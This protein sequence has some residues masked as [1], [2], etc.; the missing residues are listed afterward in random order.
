MGYGTGSF[1]PG[2]CSNRT[3]CTLGN[4]ATEPYIAG[5]NVLLAHGSAVQLYRNKYQLDQEGIIGITLNLDWAEPL[6]NTPADIS[7][8][9]RRNEFGLAWFGDPIFFGE[10]PQS[11]IDFVGSRLQQFTVDEKQLIQGS[12]DFLGLNHY[13]TKYVSSCVDKSTAQGW[14]YDQCTAESKYDMN[15]TLIG[16][17][18]GSSWLNIVPWG[19]YKVLMWT[20]ERYNNP[21]IFITE[22]GVDDID[23]PLES[24]AQALND[25]FR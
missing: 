19:M 4:S 15:G 17:Q 10:Y 9:Q 23:Q 2:R 20:S 22:N 8:A 3:L 7:A 1:A 25:T 18:A 12:V 21:G 16:P 14:Q 6:T 13:S 24:I 5:H 11:M